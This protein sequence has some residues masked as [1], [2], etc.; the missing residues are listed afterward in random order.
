[1]QP[2]SRRSFVQRTVAIAGAAS[3]A[4][5]ARA[6]G[7]RRAAA[8]AETA[9]V[10]GRVISMD[11]SISGASAVAIAGGRL[12]AVGSDADVEGLKP[13]ADPGDGRRR[14]H[15]G[16]AEEIRMAAATRT[17]AACC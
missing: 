17:T 12:I 11:G 4:G 10:G 8:S 9:I 3:L 5:P 2:I 6:L 14:R 13:G 1:M 16:R 7:R 15:G